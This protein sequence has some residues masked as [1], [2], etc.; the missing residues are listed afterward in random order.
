MSQQSLD[1]QQIRSVFIKMGSESVAERVTG[2]TVFPAELS[3]FGKDKLVYCE[4]DYVPVRMDPV[5]KEPAAWP[6]INEPVIGQDI[7]CP[8]GEECIP[9]RAGLGM[10]DM[11]AHGRTADIFIAEGADFPDAQP[12]GIHECEDGLMFTVGKRLDKSPGFFLRRNE[13]EIRIKPAHRELRRIPG[14]MEDINGKKAELG[15]AV[16]HRAVRKGTLFL[17]PADKIPQFIPGDVFRLFVENGLK[18]VQVRTNVGRI[19]FY[20]MVRKTAKGDHLP[21]R[22]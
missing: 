6:A 19:R 1:G 2:E 11:D 16:V 18:I 10:A 12:R 20:G 21:E 8:G 5:W 17:E 4:R 13:R 3:F 22:I 14:F 9:V 15:D 7:Q